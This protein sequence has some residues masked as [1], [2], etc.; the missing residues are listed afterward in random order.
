MSDTMAPPYRLILFDCVNTLYLP[1]ASRR[2]TLEIDGV[3]QASTAPLLAE[4]L[5]QRLPGLDAVELHKAQRAAWRWAES[6]RGGGHREIPAAA[7]FG[8]MLAQLGLPPEPELVA[9]LMRVHYDA[10]VGTFDLPGSH[11][12]LL[13]ELRGRFRLALFSNFDH[14]PPLAGRLARDGL[15]ERLD[16]ILISADLGWRKPGAEA[17]RIALERVGEAPG[18]ILFVGDTYGDDVVGARA[19]GIDCAWINLHGET[20][21]E[22]PAPA[23][24]L[25][26][27]L[28]LRAV[29]LPGAAQPDRRSSSEGT[30]P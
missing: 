22:G 1:D 8:R 13:D 6:Q 18:R 2:P 3:A 20:P 14:A 7:R 15:A 30:R 9:G 4:R 27:L 17:F 12:R 24:T 23:F 29:L 19:A 21:P 25:G 28:D 5:A 16:P 26:S 11:V 10:V